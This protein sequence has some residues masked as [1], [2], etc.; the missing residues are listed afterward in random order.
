MREECAGVGLVQTFL[1]RQEL[2]PCVIPIH[3]A[4]T[5]DT[6]M[7]KKLK[8]NGSAIQRH[9]LEV[10]QIQNAL[11]G[12][13]EGLRLTVQAEGRE[14]AYELCTDTRHPDLNEINRHVDSALRRAVSGYLN[15]EITE[16]PERSY[17]FFEVQDVGTHQY[18]GRRAA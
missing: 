5:P 7:K 9:K 4:K 14:Y 13:F 10:V 8:T 16:D 1:R 18:S 3:R 17:L 11:G 12:T 6:D 15:V 2:R